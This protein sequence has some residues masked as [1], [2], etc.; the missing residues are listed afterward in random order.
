MVS[1]ASS[2]A[3]SS[4][5]LRSCSTLSAISRARSSRGLSFSL[6]IAYSSV[7]VTR[8]LVRSVA[9]HPAVHTY[10]FA[11]ALH[12]LAAAPE[13]GHAFSSCLLGDPL[14]Y[15][16]PSQRRLR[17]NLRFGTFVLSNSAR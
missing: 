12:H 13:A 4:R 14:A 16:K 7:G 5:S 6:T 15:G 3:R 8:R 2:R 11:L 10:L 17:A 9:G 1:F